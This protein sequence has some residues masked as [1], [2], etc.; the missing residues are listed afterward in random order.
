MSYQER[1]TI[2][3][4]ITSISVMIIYVVYILNKYTME[5]LK[6]TTEFK[7]WGVIFLIMIG[8]SIVARIITTIILNIHYRITTKEEEPSFQDEMDKLISLKAD[9]LSLTIFTI[10]FA[11]AMSSLAFGNPIYMMFV[12]IIASGFI[13]ELGSLI[14]TLIMY[15]R[16]F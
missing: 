4:L 12:V 7:H 1:S 8:I 11:I 3:S 15:R 6:S 9:R 10:G 5:T 2:V 14:Y 13:S 16:G